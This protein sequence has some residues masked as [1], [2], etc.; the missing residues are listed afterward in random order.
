MVDLT[1]QKQVFKYN[2]LVICIF[3]TPGAVAFSYATFGYGIGSIHLDDVHCI[4]SETSLLNCAY[5]NVA[6]C[7]HSEDAGVRC[8][9][10]Y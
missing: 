8:Q 3:F 7:S 1:I 2:Y 6:Y 4:G 10:T 5:N 9:G